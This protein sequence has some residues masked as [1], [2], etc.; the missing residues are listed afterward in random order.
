MY[1][2]IYAD[3]TWTPSPFCALILLIVR[4]YYRL[5]LFYSKRISN[6]DLSNLIFF[7]FVLFYSGASCVYYFFLSN[8]IHFVYFAFPFIRVCLN[9]WVCPCSIYV[10]S[11]LSCIVCD[12]V[13]LQSN[14]NII[15]FY[16]WDSLY[17]NFWQS[18]FAE[19]FPQT[20]RRAVNKKYTISEYPTIIHSSLDPQLSFIF[21]RLV[22]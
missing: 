22:A 4:Y 20:R 1:Y 6:I 3:L 2:N 18:R 5:R 9:G 13:F 16:C 17:P 12:K 8:I 19:Q 21:R 7:L 15:I 14:N 10:L 11:T